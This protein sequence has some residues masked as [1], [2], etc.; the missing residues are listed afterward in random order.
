MKKFNKNEIVKTDPD[1]E[2]Q[3]IANDE[4]TIQKSFSQEDIAPN[5]IAQRPMSTQPD[6]FQNLNSALNNLNS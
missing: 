4:K 5:F 2:E 3:K 1:E 6:H